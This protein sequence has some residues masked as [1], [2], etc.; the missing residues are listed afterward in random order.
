MEPEFPVQPPMMSFKQ[1]LANQEDNITDEESIRRFNEY[2]L[3]FKR[4]QLVEFFDAHK[5]E[6]WWVQLRRQLSFCGIPS[7]EEANGNLLDLID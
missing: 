6:E 3:D 7:R 1:F 5:D 4:K 2:K